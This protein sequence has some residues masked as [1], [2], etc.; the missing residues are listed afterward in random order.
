MQE[1]CVADSDE[2]KEELQR[3]QSADILQSTDA[4]LEPTFDARNR[5]D[6]SPSRSFLK[7]GVSRD[8][9][10]HSIVRADIG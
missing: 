2:S 10:L 8:S 7:L 3:T 4:M 1:K 9:S 6:L 5:L